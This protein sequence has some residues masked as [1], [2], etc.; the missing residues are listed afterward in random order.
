MEKYGFFFL[1]FFFDFL[2]KKIYKFLNYV[3][4]NNVMNFFVE[5]EMVLEEGEWKD[6]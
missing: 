1:W 6:Y 2:K 4:D 3:N 5:D